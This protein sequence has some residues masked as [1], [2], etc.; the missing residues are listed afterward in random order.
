MVQHMPWMLLVWVLANQGGVPL[1]VAP[2][3][4]AAGALTGGGQAS[5]VVVLACSVAGAL[6]A[7]IL[8]YSLGRW[9]GDSTLAVCFRVMRLPPESVD[10]LGRILRAH[11]AGIMWGSRFLPE[12][13]PM[14]TGL[15][16]AAGMPLFHFLGHATGS[17]VGWAGAWIGLGYFLG[18][19]VLE[20]DAS[21][22][23]AWTAMLALSLVAAAGSVLITLVVRWRRAGSAGSAAAGSAPTPNSE[24]YTR[25]L[26][27]WTYRGSAC[28]RPGTI[29]RHNADRARAA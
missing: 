17:A 22:R 2:W 29:H 16:G 26:A 20:R 24:R 23:I 7:D 27:A 25:P 11:H 5:V 15:A 13:N 10:R 14:A 19:M 6:G 3:L 28:G 8:W 18:G 4:L 12:L 21:F 1:P 9:R